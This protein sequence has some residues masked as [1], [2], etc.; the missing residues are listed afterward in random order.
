MIVFSLM[1]HPM[2]SD[3]DR[4]IGRARAIIATGLFTVAVGCGVPPGSQSEIDSIES[5]PVVSGSE[6]QTYLQSSDSPVLVEFGVDFNCSRCVQTKS[7]VVRLRESLKGTVDVIRVDFNT[8]VQLVSQ[9]GGSICPT[10]VLFDQQTPVL[11]RSFPVS[12]D[13]LEGEILRQSETQQ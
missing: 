13:L 12:I 2:I 7:D 1:R 4:F 8:N 3:L 10:Y 5:L 9:L 11:T 6:L